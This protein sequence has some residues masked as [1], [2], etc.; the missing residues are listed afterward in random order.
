M[1]I[2]LTA[3]QRRALA[4]RDRAGRRAPVPGTAIGF[5]PGEPPT[6]THHDKILKPRGREGKLKPVD[7]PALTAARSHYLFAIPQRSGPA[8][9]GPLMLQLIFCWSDAAATEVTWRQV[10]PDAD[11]AAKVVT[12]ILAMRGW[13]ENDSRVACLEVWKVGL[14]VGHAFNPGVLVALQTMWLAPV[15]PANKLHPLQFTPLA[16]PAAAQPQPPK[17]TEHVKE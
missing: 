8:V 1:G 15:L 2:K 12:D 4:A 7:S 11:N 13:V 9:A 5:I 10:K 16:P 6:V 3:E 14:P 17:E